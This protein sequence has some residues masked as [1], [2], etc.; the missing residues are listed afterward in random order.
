MK[1]LAIIAF[2]LFTMNC[3][4]QSIKGSTSGS[5]VE[6]VSKDHTNSYIMHKPHPIL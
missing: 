6:F 1:I 2:L 3:Y 5:R 4:S